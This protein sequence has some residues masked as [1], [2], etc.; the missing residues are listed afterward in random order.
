MEKSNA[1]INYKSGSL[2]LE[3]LIAIAAA[4]II[5]TLVSQS[6]Y[7]SLYG[8]RS[9]T[10]KSVALGLAEEVFEGIN[11]ASTEKWQD[12]YTLTKNS[13]QYSVATSSN[14][15]VIN[16]GSKTITV[17]T[18]EYTEHFIVENVCR[19]GNSAT[20]N[21][22][23]I[24]DGSGTTETCVTS[25]GVHDPSTQKITITVSWQ[26]S[27]PLVISNY[28]TRWKNKICN[29]TD[30]SGAQDASATACPTNKQGGT[31]GNLDTSGGEL[32]LQ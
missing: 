3:V 31:D 8:S 28:I 29:Q 4:A 16:S 12:L 25:S 9:A 14:K 13:G 23:G 1:K 18:K 30:W 6:T 32:K 2:L 26:G 10:Q 27:D 7:V 15:W 24:T 20:R 5:V 11:A 19:D 17:D 22:T 21:I